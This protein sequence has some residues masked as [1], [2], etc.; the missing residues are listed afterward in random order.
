MSRDIVTPREIFVQILPYE[1][2]EFP[3]SE[4]VYDKMLEVMPDGHWQ[5]SSTSLGSRDEDKADNVRTLHLY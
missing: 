3:L 5:T 2:R 1:P 4:E